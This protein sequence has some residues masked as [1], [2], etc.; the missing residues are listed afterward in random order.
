MDR[1]TFLMNLSKAS[2]TLVLVPI[3]LGACSSSTENGTLGSSPP[4]GGPTSCDGVAS[5]S[6]VAQ[7]HTHTI[8][9]AATDLSNPPS[10]GATF[11]TSNAVGHS[12][13]VSFTATQLVTIGSGGTA[14]VTTTSVNGHTHDFSVMRGGAAPTPQRPPPPNGG[15]GGGRY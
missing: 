5:T 7:G 11:T 4:P 2:V 13:E 8:C 9:V 6:S 3:G 12:H 1:R 14:V 15:G 10:A